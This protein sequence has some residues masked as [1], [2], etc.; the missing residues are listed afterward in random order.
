MSTQNRPTQVFAQAMPDGAKQLRDFADKEVAASLEVA[1]QNLDALLD[2][3]DERIKLEATKF[4][5]KLN[6]FGVDRY[7]HNHSNGAVVF[8]PKRDDEK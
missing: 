8:L 1:C 3:N 7:E 5:F 4:A 6:G 2:S